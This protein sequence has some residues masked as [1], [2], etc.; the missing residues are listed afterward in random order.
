MLEVCLEPEAVG[1]RTMD[2]GTLVVHRAMKGA[3]VWPEGGD[4]E[5]EGVAIWMCMKELGG[6]GSL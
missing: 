5:V 4:V 6:E 1:I 3:F 2:G